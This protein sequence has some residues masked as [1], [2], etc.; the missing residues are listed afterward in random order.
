MYLDIKSS[1]DA[2]FVT[3]LRMVRGTEET[4]EE[5]DGWDGRS[6]GGSCDGGDPMTLKAPRDEGD[7]FQ[8]NE[9][10][11]GRNYCFKPGRSFS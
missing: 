3:G 2:A 1:A 4:K 11:S 6:R 7:N 9:A 5:S 8:P 10:L